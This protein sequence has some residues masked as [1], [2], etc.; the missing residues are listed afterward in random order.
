M[1]AKIHCLPLI[2]TTLGSRGACAY[3][4]RHWAS[5]QDT[6]WTE[7]Q[8]IAGHTHALSFTHTITHYGQ[9][10]DANQPTMHVF[11]LG[12]ET[13]V[14]GGNPRG[15]GRTCKLHAHMA[16][17]GIEP[18][19]LEGC[20]LNAL[21]VMSSPQSRKENLNPVVLYP[22]RTKTAGLSRVKRDWIIPPIRVS[23]NSKQV[24]E[25]LVQIKSD[26]IF[27]G[28][29]IYKLEGPGVDQE[30]KD[31]F[32]IDDKTGWIKSK[33][34]LDRET[35]KSFTLK[36]FALSP[37]GERLENPTTIEIYV[38]DQNDNRPTFT[39]EEFIGSVPEFSIPGTSVLTVPATDADDPNT[40]NSVL[41]Y[42]ITAQE[43]F[44]PFSINKTMF[45]IN[46][47]TGVIYTRD[48]GLDRDV[49]Q[50]FRLTL[51]VA[52]MS[53]MGLT[54]TG[55][56]IIHI[57]D[58]NNHA[59]Q[60]NPTTYTMFA[61]ENKVGEDV[62]RVNATDKDE[63][64]GDNWRITY[65]IIKGDSSGNFAIRTDQVTNQGI[66]SVVKPLDF[67]SRAEYQLT[68]RA[69]NEVPLSIK[70]PFGR[71]ST[72][73][74]T[75]RVLN[76]N[77][78]PRF[79]SNPIEV[80]IPESVEPGTV[81]ITSIAHDVENSK[82]RFEIIQDPEK[83]L[84][85]NH[86]TGDISARKNFSL[87]SPYIK[88]NKYRAVVKVTDMETHAVLQPVIDIDQG[89][90]SIPITVSDSGSPSLSSNALVNVT[91]CPCDRAGQCVSVTAAAI[92][93][94]R[95]GISFIALMIIM[96]SVA[97][98]FLLLL[99]AVAVRSCTRRGVKKEGGLLI[100]ESDDD[101]RDNVFN[102]DEQGGGEEDED[103]FNIDL[104]RT[105][106]GMVLPPESFSQPGSGLPNWKQPLRKD[107]PYNL[108]SPAY[109]RKPQGEP[110]DIED[111]ISDCLDVADN[112]PNVPPFDTAL[113]YDYEG[114]GSL[115]GSLS[116]LASSGS[117][118]DQDYDYLNNWGPRFKKLANMYDPR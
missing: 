118:E 35:H 23:E 77:E 65:S 102:Y 67:E 57:T 6:P 78:A 28:E 27:T 74:V 84:S 26:K 75:I 9:F 98:L 117:D 43:S 93:G 3:L 79:N 92:F 62:G 37:S 111:F 36:A 70:A 47:A 101:V 82:L 81:L 104:L 94:A 112:D 19:T 30:P 40:D 55:R 61:M 1:V 114:N 53:G 80:S 56:A 42:S 41:S 85:I 113:I 86:E 34:P 8:P 29:V 38:L 108:P 73:I 5:R 60:F 21:Q 52:D 24:P 95:V 46:N 13:G 109:P 107:A 32:E 110:T 72:A 69:E 59:P 89:E 103:A 33:K 10:R 49:V 88:K 18:P 63:K 31:L 50:S 51:Q 22:W 12:E 15:T 115:A 25:Y 97:F 90:F 83:W 106:N 54:S 66:I 99:L 76:E 48:V 14:P 4:R 11:G 58:I 45:G 96:A 87:R 7:C 44:P 20:Q 91:V 105:P 16:E 39:K 116:S 17:A 64:N 2:R 100:G 68:V 71:T